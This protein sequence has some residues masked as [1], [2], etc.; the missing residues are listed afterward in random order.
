[1]QFVCIYII[2]YIIIY[3]Y[4]VY[5]YICIWLHM[6]I[7]ITRVYIYTHIYIN[8]CV[9]VTSWSFI[10]I[11]VHTHIYIYI[12]YVHIYSCHLFCL[13]SPRVGCRLSPS[14]TTFLHVF[15]RS[16]WSMS[17]GFPSWCLLR[18]WN[19]GCHSWNL[20]TLA[21]AAEHWHEL[22]HMRRLKQGL[23][24][25]WPAVGDQLQRYHDLFSLFEFLVSW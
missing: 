4:I 3:I 17:P 1:M 25:G 13:T 21:R 19:F 5:I 7:I 9:C 2:I 22:M 6:H 24:Q 14:F 8:M 20:S 12:L 16:K 15:P 11:Y 18:S 23:K 10:Y